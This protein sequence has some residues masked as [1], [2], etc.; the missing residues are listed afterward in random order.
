MLTTA[1]SIS[2]VEK[3]KLLIASVFVFWNKIFIK[4]RIR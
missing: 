3:E 4:T 2:H 1:V